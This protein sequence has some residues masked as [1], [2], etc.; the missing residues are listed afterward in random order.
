MGGAAAATEARRP[1]AH[2][3]RSMQVARVDGRLEEPSKGGGGL[4]DQAESAGTAAAEGF[5]RPVRP[6]TQGGSR[7]SAEGARPISVASPWAHPMR[8]SATMARTRACAGGPAYVSC[9]HVP[10]S[11]EDERGFVGAAGAV[12]RA[13]QSCACDLLRHCVGC[14]LGLALRSIA[15]RWLVASHSHLTAVEPVAGS[16]LLRAAA[17]FSAVSCRRRAQAHAQCRGAVRL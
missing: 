17:V 11:F 2:L 3:R 13:D 9:A 7:C 16:H 15:C 10:H 1:E 8:P 5:G 4:A 14:V 6:E 12:C